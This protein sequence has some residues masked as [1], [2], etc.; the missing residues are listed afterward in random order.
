[1]KIE[2]VK[3]SYDYLPN[4]QIIRNYITDTLKEVFIKYGYNPIETPILNY[5]D[6]LSDKYDSNN[7]ILKEIY[8]LTDQGNRKLGLRYDLTVPFAKFIAI[9]KNNI[10]FPFKRYEISKAFRDGPIKKGRDREFT[11]CDCDVV[12]INGQFIEA[13][14][15]CLFID[16]FKKL[17]ID[18]IIKYNSRKLMTGLI[19]EC[20]INNSL[21][22]SVTTIIDKLDKLST[23]EFNNL[24]KEIGLNN[25]Q[26]NNI[27]KLFSYNLSELNKLFLNT[28]NNYIKE[29]LMEINEL[30]KYIND[31][32]I[33]K[34][35]KFDI[36]LARGQNYYT[37]NIFEVYDKSNTVTCS[38][39]AGGR[40]D[41]MIKNFINDGNNYDTVG[42]S[43]G[44]S[45]IYEI[46]KNRKIL[47]NI[48]I[49]IIPL[50]N[51]YISL[52]L[53]NILRN[54]NY[55][56]EIDMSFRK[57]KKIISNLSK[58]KVPYIIVLGDNEVENN[59]FKLKDMINMKEYII[60]MNNIEKIKDIIK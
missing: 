28:T 54:M 39:A 48:D 23:N 25:K 3:G 37:G 44:L 47:N 1:M 60:D 31:L 53:A 19:L 42:I 14:L 27:N 24:L 40:Y 55:K 51:N 49:Y 2:N 18:I 11:Q 43:F 4:E 5:Y 52:K 12:G 32:K 16:A 20:N 15:L 10:K 34:Y 38:I 17:D 41:L 35:C 50:N 6:M 26:I 22:S 56:V 7:D 36:N 9:N 21:V 46:L 33:D 58:N 45:A 8:K 57:L 30:T 29:G 59:Y 13:E